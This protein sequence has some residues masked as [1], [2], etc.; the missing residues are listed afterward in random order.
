MRP[1]WYYD[2]SRSTCVGPRY[3]GRSRGC[4]G[5]CRRCLDRKL[6]RI[7]IILLVRKC[8]KRSNERSICTLPSRKKYAAD[9]IGPNTVG[10][11]SQRG[12][13]EVRSMDTVSTNGQYWQEGVDGGRLIE[14]IASAHP[15]V[16]GGGRGAPGGY[17]MLVPTKD[18][19]FY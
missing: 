2:R 5:R 15:W 16:W 1:K 7:S 6:L 9:T 8:K 14:I 12:G 13:H 4:R 10:P 17:L 18:V 19:Q 3:A 11:L